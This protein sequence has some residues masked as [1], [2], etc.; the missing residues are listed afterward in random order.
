MRRGTAFYLKR[1]SKEMD[2]ATQ[3]HKPLTF[4]NV[5]GIY[6]QHC[7]LGFFGA[8]CVCVWENVWAGKY[9][10]I[11]CEQ[12]SD[13]NRDPQIG[14]I[15]PPQMGAL[16]WATLLPL[17]YKRYKQLP[18][19]SCVPHFICNPVNECLCIML[20]IEAGMSLGNFLLHGKQTIIIILKKQRIQ[21]IVAEPFNTVNIINL[22]YYKNILKKNN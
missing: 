16:V 10:I 14:P 4:L 3:I 12:F 5:V 1:R 9:H 15:T 7:W 2:I 21:C 6:V 18:V 17:N 22:C 8:L 19:K 11:S 13:S 20:Q